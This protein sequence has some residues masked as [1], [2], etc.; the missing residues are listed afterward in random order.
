MKAS[1]H[2]LIKRVAIYA[3]GALGLF[4]IGGVMGAVNAWAEGQTVPPA[5]KEA[6][7]PAAKPAGRPPT[8]LVDLDPF[9]VNLADITET[10]FAKVTIKL[11]SSAPEFSEAVDTHLPQ[12]RDAL[13]LLLGSKTSKEVRTVEG[14]LELR[15]AI[16]ERV[17]AIVGTQQA[18][19]AYFSEFV[20]Q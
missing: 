3:L 4:L 14:K 19:A 1:V 5:G 11:E 8:T 20:V 13:L 18:N 17:N 7:P 6:A 2:K 15:D 10:R 16:L 9:L 12:I